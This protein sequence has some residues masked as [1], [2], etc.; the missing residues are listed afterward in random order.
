MQ[1]LELTSGNCISTGLI[2]AFDKGAGKY[3]ATKSIRTQYDPLYLINKLKTA[4]THKNDLKV[5]WSTS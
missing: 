5:K 2:I 1:G 4:E 3:T